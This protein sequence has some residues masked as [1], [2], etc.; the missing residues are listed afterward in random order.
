MIKIGISFEIESVDLW[1]V[2]VRTTRHMTFRQPY[3][4]LNFADEFGKRFERKWTS[5][6]LFDKTTDLFV[7]VDEGIGLVLIGCKRLQSV[8]FRRDLVEHTWSMDTMLANSRTYCT[9][10]FSRPSPIPDPT[11][12]W[13]YGDEKCSH[14]NDIPMASAS[15]QELVT[16][17]RT[18]YLSRSSSEHCFCVPQSASRSPCCYR[19]SPMSAHMSGQFP[20][21]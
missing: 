16:R 8:R 7:R 17:E 14:F 5:V 3:R 20:S 18:T 10:L 11:N 21:S 15:G 2:N 13:S 4:S 1:P 6:Q 12:R 9:C 19:S